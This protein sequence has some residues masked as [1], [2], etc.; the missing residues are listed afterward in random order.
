MREWEK[1][2]KMLWGP[3][4][5]TL[6]ILLCLSLPLLAADTS[7]PLQSG[8]EQSGPAALRLT[9]PSETS[10]GQSVT[11]I[12]HGLPAVDL[13]ATVGEQT[14]WVETLRFAVSAPD[15]VEVTLDKELSMTVA[16]WG[17][18]LRV[19]FIPPVDGTYVLVCDW[20]QEPFGLALHRMLVGPRPPPVDPIK[21]P[22]LTTRATAAVYV[23]EKDQG[24]PPPPVSA[25]LH[26]LNTERESFVASAVDQDIV[27]GAGQ[28]PEQFRAAIQAAKQAGLPALVVMSGANVLRVVRNPTTVEAVM[29]AVQ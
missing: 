15:G 24:T 29:E 14:A 9:G 28:V 2:Q 22:P 1:V 13:T 11:V 26:R 7:T 12:V 23:F 5:K 21:P 27:T 20:N 3:Q 6:L 16:P 10:A 18:R 17:W 25:A 19:S 8:Q 4:M